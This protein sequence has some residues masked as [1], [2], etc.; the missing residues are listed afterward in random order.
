MGL[1]GYDE[2]DAKKTVEVV[3]PCHT[4]TTLR[5]I[6]HVFTMSTVCGLEETP[7]TVMKKTRDLAKRTWNPFPVQK[8]IDYNT[9]TEIGPM[10]PQISRKITLLGVPKQEV[11]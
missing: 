10:S 1:V 6:V 5:R 3:G 8:S 2:G 11:S 9:R 4:K 7:R